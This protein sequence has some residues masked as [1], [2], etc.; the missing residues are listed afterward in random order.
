MNGRKGR[1]KHESEHVESGIEANLPIKEKESF[2]WS[3]SCRAIAE[4][5]KLCPDKMLTSVRH[6]EADLCHL[7]HEASGL[8][9]SL[10]DPGGSREAEHRLGADPKTKKV[11]RPERFG[12]PARGPTAPSVQ[13]ATRW[14]GKMGGWLARGKQDHPGTTCIWRGLVRLPTLVQG[15]LLA[16]HI[17]GIRA[18]P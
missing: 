7:F 11:A 14:I 9:G 4:A 5:Q 8:A 17:H 6:R 3:V 1:Q 15:Y 13:Q 18:N 2:K 12:L 10:A 16:P